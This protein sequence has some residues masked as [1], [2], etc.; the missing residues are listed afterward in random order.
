MGHVFV[1]SSDVLAMALPPLLSA[2][3][4]DGEAHSWLRCL[5]GLQEATREVRLQVGAPGLS[6]RSQISAPM[7]LAA[8][9]LFGHCDSSQ[10]T[11]LLTHPQ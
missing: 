5:G 7:E 4:R 9:F 10:V 2:E 1:R 8:T 11:R 6:S 3:P